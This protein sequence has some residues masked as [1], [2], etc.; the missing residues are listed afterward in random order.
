MVQKF[1]GL[2]QKSTVL[3]GAMGLRGVLLQSKRKA[4]M[5]GKTKMMSK[6]AKQM[7]RTTVTTHGKKLKRF[8]GGSAERAAL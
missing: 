2:G 8:E 6:V 4:E 3:C 5:E 7:Q 1:R